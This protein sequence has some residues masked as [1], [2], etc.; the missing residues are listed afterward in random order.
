MVKP[1]QI[2]RGELK[3]FKV[4]SSRPWFRVPQNFIKMAEDG[5]GLFRLR[6]TRFKEI[7]VFKSSKQKVPNWKHSVT[8]PPREGVRHQDQL[9]RFLVKQE[10][11]Q[12]T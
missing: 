3:S 7:N 11:N 2:Q 1:W 6:L 5:F 4:K 12:H 8:E 9:K 10:H